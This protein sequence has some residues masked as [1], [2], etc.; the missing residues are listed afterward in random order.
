MVQ[1][2]LDAIAAHLVNRVH[3]IRQMHFHAAHLAK[4]L[5][6]RSALRPLHAPAAN[7]LTNFIQIF[8]E[9]LLGNHDSPL[10][11]LRADYLLQLWFEFG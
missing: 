6:W 10:S 3:Q 7:V 8:S 9:F 11:L 5:A 4:G 2:R 1:I